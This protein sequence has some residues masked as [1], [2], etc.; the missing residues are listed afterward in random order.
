MLNGSLFVHTVDW[1][2]SAPHQLGAYYYINTC[3]VTVTRPGLLLHS[4]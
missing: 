2:F 4:W 3:I 1:L